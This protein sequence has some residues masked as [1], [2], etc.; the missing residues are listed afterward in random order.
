MVR[1]VFAEFRATV[2]SLVSLGMR[3][4]FIV[5]GPILG[6]LVDSYGV[7]ISF[8]VL[9]AWFLPTVIFVLFGLA[10]QIQ[11]KEQEKSAELEPMLY[12]Q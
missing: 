9:A 11:V 7:N 8:L 1:L 3:S 6:F 4:T 5:A 12:E 2:N 10:K